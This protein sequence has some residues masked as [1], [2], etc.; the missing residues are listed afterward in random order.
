MA[1]LLGLSVLVSSLWLAGCAREAALPAPSAQA[2]TPE[3]TG[4]PRVTVH[5]SNN[6]ADERD[7]S[8]VEL[9]PDGAFTSEHEMSNGGS[10][11]TVTACRGALP[12]PHAA[13]WV[14]RVRSQATL[15]AP[16]RGPSREEIDAKKIP[17]RHEV[18]YSAAP[19]AARYAD[20]GTSTRDLEALLQELRPLSRCTTFTR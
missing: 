7:T 19:G 5:S 18:S 16:P 2:T 9:W 1:R 12:A 17:Y 8:R 6:F 3:P 10:T 20:L 14:A 4:Y 11:S 13:A 15:D